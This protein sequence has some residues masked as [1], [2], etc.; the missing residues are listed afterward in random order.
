MI[1]KRKRLVRFPQRGSVTAHRG[2]VCFPC[3]TVFP[4]GD[5]RCGARRACRRRC[6]TET[7]GQ[8]LDG[9]LAK[10]PSHQAKDVAPSPGRPRRRRRPARGC[11][12]LA[13]R[14]RRKAATQTPAQRA[15]RLPSPGH[16]LHGWTLD[17]TWHGHP[18]A[19]TTS[20]EGSELPL[21]YDIQFLEECLIRIPLEA[22]YHLHWQ[23]L[24]QQEARVLY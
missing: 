7:A 4:R 2:G 15:N 12:W 18:H 5:P 6:P 10:E 21:K 20:P 17:L 16:R 24:L 22:R 13:R 3:P 11:A 19:L 14:A 9:L 23:A 8:L 1:A